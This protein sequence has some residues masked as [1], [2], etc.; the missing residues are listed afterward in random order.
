MKRMLFGLFN[1]LACV[2]FFFSCASVP[3]ESDI[4]QN[5]SPAELAQQA[6]N[7][8]DLGSVE[9]A[10]VYYQTILHRFAD[11]PVAVASAEF[12]LAHIK[13]K[14]KQWS[15]ALVLLDALIEKYDN[16]TLYELPRSYLKLAELDRE[17]IP[18]KY[19][20]LPVEAQTDTQLESF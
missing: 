20:P 1:F 18:K 5:L 14:K 15:E 12:E 13:I 11:D 8:F 2:L 6:Q 9:T 19:V 4:P 10:Q 16:D 17:K 7:N 3:T